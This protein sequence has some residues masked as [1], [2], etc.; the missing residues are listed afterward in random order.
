LIINKAKLGGEKMSH[1]TVGVI[2]DKNKIDNRVDDAIKKMKEET[3]KDATDKEILE[4]R[5][6][7]IQYEVSKAL[8]PFDEGLEVDP[9][10]DITKDE[11]IKEHEEIKSFTEEEKRES[12]YKNDLYE[13]YSNLSLEEFVTK[14]YCKD[15]TDEGIMS[16]YN[17]NSKWDWNV[18]GGRWSNTLPIKNKVLDTIT[19]NYA[20]D[21]N[22]FER[23]ENIIFNKNLCE[24]EI[25][26]CK[27]DYK[28]L[29]A[30]GSYYSPKYYKKRYPTFESYLESRSNFTTYALLTSDGVWHEP[31]EMGWFGISSASPEQET[32]FK[33]T[34]DKLIKKEDPKN[35]FVLVDCHI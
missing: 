9:Y 2:I 30:E 31:A 20:D 33:R 17:P 7:A 14:Y 35:Y 16:T 34:Y 3:N 8:E 4:A 15:L 25:K 11:L 12:V 21:P 19:T 23:I 5:F 26:A 13:E 27:T 24:E 18:I 32:E 6:I 22:S 10:V 28:Y 29:I 1:Y